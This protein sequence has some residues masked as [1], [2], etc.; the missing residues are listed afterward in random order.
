MAAG[1]CYNCLLYYDNGH[2]MGI[3]ITAHAYTVYEMV[4]FLGPS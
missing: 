2:L 4:F 1:K 3:N